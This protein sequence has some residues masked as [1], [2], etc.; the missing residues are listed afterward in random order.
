[1]DDGDHLDHEAAVENA[2]EHT[3]LT[4]PRRV[5]R[6]ERFAERSSDAVGSAAMR[7]GRGDE[8]LVDIVA[9]A[10]ERDVYSR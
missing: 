9:L 10:H 8:T 4:A 1:M 2:I 5:E 6:S 7:E 3:I